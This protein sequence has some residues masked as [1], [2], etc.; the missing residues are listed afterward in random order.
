MEIIDFFFTY[1]LLNF[2]LTPPLSCSPSLIKCTS[3]LDESGKKVWEKKKKSLN[4]GLLQIWVKKKK[5]KSQNKYDV[6]DEFLNFYSN[7]EFGCIKKEEA[8]IGGAKPN[9]VP[10]TTTKLP[11]MV[12]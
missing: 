11:N 2:F 12:E 1:I 4:L 10:V 7:F 9:P 6:G 8:R 5:D 3:A